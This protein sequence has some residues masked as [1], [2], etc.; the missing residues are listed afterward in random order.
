MSALLIIESAGFNVVLTG[1]NLA[2]SPASNL[3][4][5]QKD[6]L[7]SHKAEIIS[8]LEII[9]LSKAGQKITPQVTCRNCASFTSFNA[10]GGGA[11][12]CV[13]GVWTAGICRWSDD[14]HPCDK[15]RLKTI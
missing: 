6:F 2:I 5:P 7:K 15:Y 14:I 11:G 12:L 8:E 4:Q 13:A 9:A 10:H 1:G 3:T